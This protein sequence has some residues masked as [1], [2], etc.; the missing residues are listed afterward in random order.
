MKAESKHDII[1]PVW[2]IYS[3]PIADKF[4]IFE[5]LQADDLSHQK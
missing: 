5:F 1:E 4:P 3:S 2:K